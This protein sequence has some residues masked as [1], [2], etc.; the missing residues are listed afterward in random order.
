M[1]HRLSIVLAAL[2]AG[3]A[4]FSSPSQTAPPLV[5]LISV[6]GLKPEAIIEAPAHGLKVPNLRAIMTDGVYATGV[7]GVLP[8]S[9]NSEK[10]IAG[11]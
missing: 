8:K 4:A 5:V 10:A 7:R 2:L 11:G 6:D 1:N 3:T 9:E